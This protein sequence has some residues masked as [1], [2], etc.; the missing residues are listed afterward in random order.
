MKLDD[1]I[2]LDD[3][4]KLAQGFL[5]RMLFDYIEGGAEDEVGLARNRAAWQAHKLLPRYLVNVGTVDTGMTLFGKRYAYPFGVAPMGGPGLFRRGAD[6]WMAQ[7]AAAANIPYVM[8]T[9]ST[10]SLEAAA[11]VAPDHTWFQLYGS[12]DRKITFDMVRRA[13]DAG[14]KT[15]VWSVDVPAGANRERNRRNRFKRH[16]QIT[17]G[18]LGQMLARPGWLLDYLRHGGLPPTSNYAP[19]VTDARGAANTT[20]QAELY[21]ANIPAPDQTWS[22]L[23]ELRRLW[24]GNLVIKG[25]LHPD[26][27][28][29]AKQGGA[30]GVIISNH[31]ARQLDSAPATVS[32][33]PQVAAAAGNGLTVMIDSGIRR[34]SDLIIARCLGAT[35]GF[36]GRPFMYGA[37]GGGPDGARKVVQILDFELKLTLAQIGCPRFDDLGP[38]FLAPTALVNA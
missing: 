1:V 16:M 9:L 14:I 11:K 2:N 23:D 5:P 28:R 25:I 35:C 15:L 8:S 12:R 7:A 10:E 33:L 31:G 36:L 19:Y 18:V 20:A 30:N 38:Q 24:P 37:V 27:A 13:R 22:L 29:L 21:E 6:L 26:D 4:S 34:G 3:L 17:P 32:M